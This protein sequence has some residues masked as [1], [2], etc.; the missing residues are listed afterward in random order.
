MRNSHSRSD[1]T[2]DQQQSILDLKISTEVAITTSFGSLFHAF[3]TLFEKKCA[4]IEV[5]VCGFSNFSG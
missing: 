2:E 3:M 4:R 1:N 5:L